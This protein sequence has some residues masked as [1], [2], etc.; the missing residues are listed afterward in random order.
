MAVMHQL[1]M[2]IYGFVLLLIMYRTTSKEETGRWL[3]FI[4]TISLADMLLHGFFQTPVIRKIS[5]E[6]ADQKQINTISSNAFAYSLMIWGILSVAIIIGNIANPRSEALHDLRWYIPIGACMAFYNL[7]W[8]TGNALSDFKSVFIQRAIF[9]AISAS[10]ILV[11]LLKNGTLNLNEIALSQ[12]IA[13]VISSYIGV[14]IIRRIKISIQ[15]I[16]LESFKY[17][18]GYGR[19]TAGSMI[20]G[21]ILRNADVFMIAYFLGRSPLA[22]YSAAQKTVE[23]F[24]VPLRG[25]AAHSFTEFCKYSDNIQHLAKRYFLITGRL[26]LFFLGALVFMS[27]F[28]EKVIRLLSG[29]YSY[30]GAALLLRIFMVYVIFLTADRMIGVVLEALGLVKYNLMKTMIVAAVN[31]AGNFVALYYFH[32][33]AGVAAVSILA[34]IAG[35]ISGTYFITARTSFVLSKHH[36]QTGLNNILKWRLQ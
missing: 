6:N 1:L 22:I 16:D 36:I 30:N 12:L 21:S 4:S 15:H 3:L 28:S 24:E 18:I 26:I 7:G 14:K 32:S 5:S 20:M 13:Y 9:S 34:V 19:F 23:I 25:M 8:W 35:I 11:F 17:F 2:A 27:V 29:S 31:I 33:L 10:I